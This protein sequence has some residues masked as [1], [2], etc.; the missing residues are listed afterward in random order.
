[1]ITAFGGATPQ[2]SQGGRAQQLRTLFALA[3]AEGE[4][5]LHA[6]AAS[7]SGGI[8]PAIVLLQRRIGGRRGAAGARPALAQRTAHVTGRALQDVTVQVG[9][10]AAVHLTFG[11]PERSRPSFRPEIEQK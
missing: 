9:P 2:R 8:L 5:A 7:A 3:L 4:G 6:P 11:A 1:M 10:G